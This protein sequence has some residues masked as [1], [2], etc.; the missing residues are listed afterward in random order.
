M[1]SPLTS[2]A[3]FIARDDRADDDLAKRP[4]VEQPRAGYRVQMIAT[5][6]THLIVPEHT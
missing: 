4:I 1:A 5:A 6:A 2:Q 3:D